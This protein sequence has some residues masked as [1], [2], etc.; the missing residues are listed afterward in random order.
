MSHGRGCVELNAPLAKS[1]GKLWKQD[2]KEE[3]RGGNFFIPDSAEAKNSPDS[4]DCKKK[5]ICQRLR[6]TE[7]VSHVAILL[8]TVTVVP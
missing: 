3:A 4:D 8:S 2:N 1:Q 7:P 5:R 6:N